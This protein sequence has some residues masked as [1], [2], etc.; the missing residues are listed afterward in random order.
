VILKQRRFKTY[1]KTSTEENI[2][3]VVTSLNDD[4][5]SRILASGFGTLLFE[6]FYNY[7]SISL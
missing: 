7:R 6:S 5:I 3:V 1:I 4:L 2:I